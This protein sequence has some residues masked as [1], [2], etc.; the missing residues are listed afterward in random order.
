MGCF[1]QSQMIPM[2]RKSGECL[3]L[4]EWPP[5]ELSEELRFKAGMN[6]KRER[7]RSPRKNAN[8]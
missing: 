3:K 7:G 5:K 6:R 2:R 1:F 4:P 8:K